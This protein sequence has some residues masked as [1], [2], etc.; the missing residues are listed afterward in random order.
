M[1]VYSKTMAGRK[2]AI[3]LQSAVPPE[4]ISFLKRIDGKTPDDTL[5]AQW[6][7]GPDAIQMLRELERKGLIEVREQRWSKSAYSSIHSQA[8]KPAPIDPVNENAQ[9]Q[10]AQDELDRIKDHMSTFILMHLPHRA[11][12]ALKDIE[13]IHSHDK[14]QSMLPSYASLAAEAGRDGLAHIKSLR[15]M[16]APE[17]ENTIS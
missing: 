3:E 12:T 4:L 8:T 15:S 14:L 10:S 13:D 6:R 11:M 9:D 17:F 7:D 16:L 5:I 1:T 2:A